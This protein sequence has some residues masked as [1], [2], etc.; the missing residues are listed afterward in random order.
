MNEGVLVIGYGNALRTDDGLGR[1]AAERLADDPRLDGATVVACHQL[2]PELV[3]DVSR[4]TLV[5][6]VDANHGPPAGT[7]KIERMERTGRGASGWSHQLDPSSLVDLADELY[8]RVPDVFLV[9]VGVESLSFGD[10]LSPVVEAALPRL[11]D[12]VAKLVADWTSQPMTV[13]IAE[14]S[15]A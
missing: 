14:H 11:V 2:T 12:T 15:G 3:L 5:V 7:F 13:P 4:A 6:F 9:T 8:G 1:H 10:R